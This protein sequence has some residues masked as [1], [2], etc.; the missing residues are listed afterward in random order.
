MFHV[1][2]TKHVTRACGINTHLS[3]ID[4]TEYNNVCPSC[5]VPLEVTSHIV[6]CQDKSRTEL[7][8]GTVAE[9]VKCIHLNGTDPEIV[10]LVEDYLQLRD[11]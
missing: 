10:T 9:M 8:H 5:G 1:F 3:K 6:R 11:E 4:S 7:F 2:I